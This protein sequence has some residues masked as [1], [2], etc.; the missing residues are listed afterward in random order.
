MAAALMVLPGIV[1]VIV[2]V[3]MPVIVAVVVT[4]MM[5]VVMVMQV[6][7]SARQSRIFTEHQRLDGH[8]HGHRRQADA[9]EVDIVEI[10]QHDAVDAEDFAFDVQLFAQD[11][12]QRLRDVAVEHDVKRLSLRNGVGNAADDALCKCKDAVVRGA[13][14]QRNA[15]A[16]SASPSVRSNA[17]K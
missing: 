15:S 5:V 16:T 12:A 17:V 4:M 9:A 13:P 7:L 10:P 2:A 1:H 11:R 14:R 8:R 3:I 6:R